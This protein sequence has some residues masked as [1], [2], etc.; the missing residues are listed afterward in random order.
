MSVTSSV[1]PGSVENS[2]RMPRMRTAVILI[3]S[4]NRVTSYHI[5]P[6]CNFLCQLQ[7]EKVLHVFGR[8]NVPPEHLV[9][10]CEDATGRELKIPGVALSTR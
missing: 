4:P 2:W 1:T 9:I 8:E 5:D 10:V 3:T 6:D 7:G